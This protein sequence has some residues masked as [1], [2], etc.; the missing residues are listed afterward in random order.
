MCI[1]ATL[2]GENAKR[3]LEG[4]LRRFPDLQING[5]PIPQD[6]MELFHGLASLPVRS[7]SMSTD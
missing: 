3:A 2:A 7:P 5:T 6:T 4:V 1:G